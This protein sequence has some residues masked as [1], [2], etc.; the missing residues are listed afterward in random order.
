MV[1]VLDGTT[2]PATVRREGVIAFEV[3]SD[4]T[5]IDNGKLGG[6]PGTGLQPGKQFEYVLSTLSAGD[7][8]LTMCTSMIV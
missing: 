6:A 1:I 8:N 7:Y 5:Y 3:S 4:G 2:P